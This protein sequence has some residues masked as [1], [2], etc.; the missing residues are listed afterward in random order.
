MANSLPGT[1]L[2]RGF[3]PERE[4]PMNG[5]RSEMIARMH[6]LFNREMSLLVYEIRQDILHESQLCFSERCSLSQ[7]TISRLEN[8]CET[9]HFSLDSI[10]AITNGIHIHISEFFSVVEKNLLEK[11]PIFK[12]APERSSPFYRSYPDNV[13]WDNINRQ[14]IL[15]RAANILFK[16][17]NSGDVS[18]INE[19]LLESLKRIISD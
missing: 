8:A 19:Q 13:S 14:M 17:I 7:K 9:D 5:N 2:L 15:I 3:T 1:F 4:D 10:L 16:L 6:Q 12:D 18:D 11:E